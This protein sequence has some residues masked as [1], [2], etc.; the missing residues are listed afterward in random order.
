MTIKQCGMLQTFLLSMTISFAGCGEKPKT[1]KEYPIK[2]TVTAID[3]DKTH[4]TLDHEDIPGLM[5]AM[6]ME[7]PVSDPKVLEG[8]SAGD[9]VEGQLRNSDELMITRLQKR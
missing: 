3:A 8:I 1:P 6:E 9:G 4:V 7:F 5:R 2:G